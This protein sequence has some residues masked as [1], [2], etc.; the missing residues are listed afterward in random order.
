MYHV[1]KVDSANILNNFS[2]PSFLSS[3][4]LT[5]R[6]WSFLPEIFQNLHKCSLYILSCPY[7]IHSSFCLV[8]LIFL[9]YKLYQSVLFLKSC[10]AFKIKSKFTSWPRRLF[11]HWKPHS[12]KLPFIISFL[13][14]TPYKITFCYPNILRDFMH[15]K[16][17]C[18]LALD[19]FFPL[20][21]PC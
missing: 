11:W 5:F 14:S 21:L 9:R 3:L 7:R 1:I 16:S 10:T 20:P 4:I 2:T 19:I 18:S 17:F 15:L 6:F 8:R 13:L 12:P